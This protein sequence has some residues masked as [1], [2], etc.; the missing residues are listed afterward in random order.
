[1]KRLCQLG[2]AAALVLATSMGCNK[3]ANPVVP[4]GAAVLHLN[5]PSKIL[6]RL[7]KTVSNQSVVPVSGQGALEYYLSTAGQAP[8]TGVILFNDGSQVGNVFIN[9]PQAGLW[10]VATEWFE[11]SNPLLGTKNP[12]AKLVLPGLN[13]NPEFV[14]ADQVNVQGTTSFT[15]NM[16][17]IGSTGGEGTCYNGTITDSTDCDFGLNGAWVDLYTFNNGVEAAS[18]TSVASVADIQA[19]Y[20]PVTTLSTYLSS[21]MGATYTY[22]GNGD[23]VNFPVVPAGASFYPD[24]IAAKTAV[25]GSAAASIATNDIFVVKGPE[26]N[27]MVWLQVWI[28]NNVCT[29]GPG[30]S[31]LMQ[32]WY[33]Y[34]NENLN[35]MK[36][37]ETTNGHIN[38]NQNTVPTATPTSTST[39]TPTATP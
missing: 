2:S 37:D 16:E 26:T 32:F 6:S 29:A 34:N 35:Y 13:A 7:S 11:V 18:N 22:L 14:G 5:I 8:V 24:T 17:D 33:V 1:M 27:Q 21:P 39:P 19:L 20:D 28:N 23:L 31:S 15:L 12:S 4:A 3:T 30:G 25:V 9:L 36:F 38:C 10:L